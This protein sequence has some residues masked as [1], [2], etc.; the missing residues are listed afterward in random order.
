M[1]LMLQQDAPGDYVIATG[2]THCVRE[3]VA[4]SFGLAGLDW[5]DYVTIDPRY[6]RP[7]EVDVLIGDPTKARSELDWQAA[8]TFQ[9]LVRLMLD[10]DMSDAGIQL[11]PR[12][13]K[14]SGPTPR[15]ASA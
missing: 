6:Y 9:E 12:S 14:G 5:Q 3:F 10:A 2:E 1:W 8:T 13:W 4:E 7:T 15:A 11:D